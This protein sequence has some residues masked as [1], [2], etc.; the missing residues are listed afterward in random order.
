MTFDFDP[1]KSRRN[2]ENHGIDFEEAQRLW[3]GNHVV[4]PAK[5]VQG[6][7]RFAILGKIESKVYVGIFTVRDDVTRIISCHRA[8]KKWEGIYYEHL[9][10]KET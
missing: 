6:E 4:I 7:G 10:K 9:Q 2:F 1:A 3:D 5:N 8:D